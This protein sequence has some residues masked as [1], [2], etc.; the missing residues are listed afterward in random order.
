MLYYTLVCPAFAAP[1]CPRFHFRQ[2]RQHVASHRVTPLQKQP[3]FG[4]D[5][6]WFEL[7]Y[8]SHAV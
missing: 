3:D 7:A 6:S 5:F 8:A 2:D 4:T 1:F